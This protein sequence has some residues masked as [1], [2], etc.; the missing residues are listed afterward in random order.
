MNINYAFRGFQ[1]NSDR[2]K[3][4]ASKKLNKIEK[5]V[6]ANTLIEIV[7]QK[8]KNLKYTEIKLNHQGEDFI[9]RESDD[10]DFSKSIDFCVDKLAE[11]IK[12]AKNRKI[13]QRRS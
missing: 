6:S 5:L 13:D 2:L 1:E 7:F 11:Q 9:A 12:R 4:Y 10:K 8:E 3:D